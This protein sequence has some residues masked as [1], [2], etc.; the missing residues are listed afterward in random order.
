MS[1][2]SLPGAGRVRRGEQTRR[3]VELA[4]AGLF[5]DHG[6]AGTSIQAV[7]SAA[8]VHAQTIYQAYGTKAAL[9]AAV[10]SRLVAGDDDPA[11]HPSQ[12]SWVLRIQAEPDPARKL[13]LYVQHICEVTPRVVALV[14]M[15]RATAPAEPDVAAFLEQM[16]QGRHLGPANLLVPLAEQ[17][18]LR[19]GLTLAA[20]ADIT[21]A[22]VSPDTFRALV[23]GRGWSWGRA[24]RWLT[25]CLTQ[26][27]L[28]SRPTG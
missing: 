13:R 6:Y 27:L 24:E 9:L 12:R 21:Y 19:P 1:T 15:L 7:A 3:R 5:G 8:G 2:G 28:A 18:C 20:A 26:A 10:G 22:L 23:L 4:A 25:E 16:E 17:G 14:D 11:L